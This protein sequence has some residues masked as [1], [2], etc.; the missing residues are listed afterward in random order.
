MILLDRADFEIPPLLSKEGIEGWFKHDMYIFHT[1]LQW[2]ILVQPP[3][4]LLHKEGIY[5]NPTFIPCY[6]NKTPA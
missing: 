2:K 5:P 4:P 1:V 6:L 3:L